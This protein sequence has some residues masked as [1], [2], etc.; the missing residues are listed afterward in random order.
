ML[1]RL[2][3]IILETVF[4]TR[5]KILY[6]NTP[7]KNKFKLRNLIKLTAKMEKTPRKLQTIKLKVNY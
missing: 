6:I 1:H 3:R 5:S 4:I 2:M 7:E